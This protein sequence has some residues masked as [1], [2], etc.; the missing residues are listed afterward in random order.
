MSEQNP[1]HSEGPVQTSAG[2]SVQIGGPVDAR[3]GDFIDWDAQFMEKGLAPPAAANEYGTPSVLHGKPTGF[4]RLGGAPPP[5]V[6]D[7]PGRTVE[8]Q[9]APQGHAA[10]MLPQGPP[11]AFEA[12]QGAPQAHAGHDPRN[13]MP[14]AGQLA[15]V[16]MKAHGPPMPPFQGEQP[17]HGAMGAKPA[18]EGVPPA[19]KMGDDSWIDWGEIGRMAAVEGA[20]KNPKVGRYAGAEHTENT[21]GRGTG[22]TYTYPADG[23]G[24]DEEME[25]SMGDAFDVL[26]KGALSIA[27]GGDPVPFGSALA[28]GGK[29]SGGGWHPIPGGKKGG[30]RRKQGSRYVYWYPDGTSGRSKKRP[31]KGGDDTPQLGFDFGGGRGS[32]PESG[33]EVSLVDSVLKE[34]G[35][36]SLT[37]GERTALYQAKRAVLRA[38]MEG[39][40]KPRQLGAAVDALERA[41]DVSDGSEEDAANIRKLAEAVVKTANAGAVPSPL[42]PAPS[43]KYRDAA[44][45]A[46]RDFLTG[47]RQ[48]SANPGARSRAEYDEDF[49]RKIR[50]IVADSG[51]EGFVDMM[52]RSLPEGGFGATVAPIRYVREKL[53][54]MLPDGHP[55]KRGVDMKK[56]P[57]PPKPDR[58]KASGTAEAFYNRWR[59]GGLPWK[60]PDAERMRADL[61]ASGAKMIDRS[62]RSSVASHWDPKEGGGEG[63]AEIWEFP[64]GKT[65]GLIPRVTRGRSG[66]EPFPNIGRP[67]KEPEPPSEPSGPRPGTTSVRLPKFKAPNDKGADV[68]AVREI[69]SAARG[70]GSGGITDDASQ[71]VWITKQANKVLRA[72]KL[73]RDEELPH[74]GNAV[75]EAH[76]RMVDR[77]N[78]LRSRGLDDA[79]EAAEHLGS[80]LEKL[81]EKIKKKLIAGAGQKRKGQIRRKVAKESSARQGS[82]SSVSLSEKIGLRT[83]HFGSE[84]KQIM[85]LGD[86]SPDT[87]QKVLGLA[88]EMAEAMLRG[89]GSSEFDPAKIVDREHAEDASRHLG[90]AATAAIRA[91]TEIERAANFLSG[92]GRTAA[93]NRTG[94]TLRQAH[95]KIENARLK[96]MDDLDTLGPLRRGE[97]DAAGKVEGEGAAAK[98]L[99]KVPEPAGGDDYVGG[100]IREELSNLGQG[101]ALSD[102]HVFDR[103][104]T[105]ARNALRGMGSQQQKE[106]PAV[107]NALREAHARMVDHANNMKSL[108]RTGH[109]REVYKHLDDLADMHAQVVGKIK[110]SYHRSMPL[111]E[112]DAYGRTLSKGW[113]DF[114]NPS[115]QASALPEDMLYDYL[116]AAVEQAYEHESRES[117]HRGLATVGRKLDEMAR[118]VMLSL[119]QAAPNN[120]NLRRAMAAC[121]CD[122]ASV[123]QML[124]AHG[125]YQGGHDGGWTSDQDSHAAMMG[126][127]G[128][129]FALSQNPEAI[130][131]LTV[132]HDPGSVAHLVKSDAIDPFAF[133]RNRML[134]NEARMRAAFAPDVVSKGGNIDARCPVHGTLDAYKSMNLHN[135]MAPCTC[136]GTPRPYA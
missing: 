49:L 74:V 136:H 101:D 29:P 40:S 6:I 100:K 70:F 13:P 17:M 26:M 43:T 134:R 84:I 59:A 60:G 19:A 88:G 3:H 1:K 110:K 102:K 35:R 42:P 5:A 71:V 128:G 131:P 79:A 34:T 123:A 22:G 18:P 23:E 39:W 105:H 96:I 62:D 57:V 135:P 115:P 82:I 61:R 53:A 31:K 64:D 99:D 91:G 113:Y 89:E 126:I 78:E 38:Q 103:V 90:Y 46:L 133:A 66:W 52:L 45:D 85:P 30:M 50:K 41:A 80:D 104:W 112:I 48:L 11:A 98:R 4:G 114:L 27:Q 7:V 119:V 75:V 109:A 65:M 51:N 33:G 130:R 72:G 21:G 111:T 107:A 124:T 132:R 95:K 9:N 8:P 108:G 55:D 36:T 94:D 87:A 54:A 69:K 122:K 15:P 120:R 68:R 93:Q 10:P 44:K 83:E 14:F 121:P 81:H 77:I 16:M 12:P 97:V 28:K 129:T 2:F 73:A 116:V 47:M 37:R 63:F 86:P 58:M 76:A 20:K 125:I 25:L 56:V 32:P 117:A 118:A 67:V 24:E 92:P 127:S 106:L